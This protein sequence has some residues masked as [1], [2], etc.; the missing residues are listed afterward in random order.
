M[1]DDEYDNP[2]PPEEIPDE[3]MPWITNELTIISKI[4]K[5]KRK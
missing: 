4:P 2:S 5:K 3:D 1:T